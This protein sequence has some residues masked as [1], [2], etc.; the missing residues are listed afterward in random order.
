MRFDRCNGFAALIGA[1]AVVSVGF[2]G[3]NEVC[4]QVVID[5]DMVIHANHSFP[6]SGIKVIDG[7]NPPTIVEVASGGEI[8]NPNF[9]VSSAKVLALLASLEDKQVHGPCPVQ[10]R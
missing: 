6:D 1:V 2:V 4:G 5:T 9:A 8:A 7:A 10:A 3:L